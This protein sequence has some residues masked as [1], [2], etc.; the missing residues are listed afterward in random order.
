[1]ACYT[2]AECG[3]LDGGGI[4]ISNELVTVSDT[5]INLH[6]KAYDD[7]PSPMKLQKLCYYAQA[8]HM[9]AK[10]GEELFSE[11]FQAWTH[12]PVIAALYHKFKEF[13]WRSISTEIAEVVLPK[14]T[15]E[16]L[17]LIVDSYGRYDGAA[18]STMTH[19]ESPWLEARADLAET[20]GS[21]KIISKES[22]RL[23]FTQ[24]LTA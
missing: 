24:Q 10:G 18:L 5:L 15:V 19:Q 13:G 23:F 4:M 3:R 12:G 9:A 1:M 8:I 14:E 20:E 22:M 21:N 17:S 2:R 7:S 16:F 6:R 11:D